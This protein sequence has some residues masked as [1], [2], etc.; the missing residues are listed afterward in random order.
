MSIISLTGRDDKGRF[1][2]GC[3]SIR[4]GLTLE[5]LYGIERAQQIRKNQSK[6]HKDIPRPYRQKRIKKERLKELYIDEHLTIEQCAN[7]FECSETAI[8]NALTRFGF[9]IRKLSDYIKGIPR[10]EETKRKLSEALKGLNTW[11]KGRHLSEKT[12]K[13]LSENHKGKNHPMFGKHHTEES[14]NK[15]SKAKKG[16]HLTEETKRKIS[17]SNKGRKGYWKGKKRTKE[18]IKKW[19]RRRIPT[20]LEEKFEGIINKYHLPYKYTGD[21]SFFIENYN[22]DFINTNSEKIAIEVYARL[23]KQLDGRNIEDWKKKRTKVFAKYGWKIIYFD[24][25]EVN[26]DYVLSKLRGGA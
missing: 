25:T 15:I 10:S 12:R 2:K 4:K 14:K 23:F 6:S 3:V 5:Q 13:K 26:E 17:E 1:V 24:E 20:S 21:G 18:D 8:R 22:P 9:H 11:M 19:L 16:K 7:K